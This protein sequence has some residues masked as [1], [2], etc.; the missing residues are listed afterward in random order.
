MFRFTEG[1]T[2][3]LPKVTNRWRIA[4][5]K[6]V[7][8]K[9]TISENEDTEESDTEESDMESDMDNKS[10]TL[11]DILAQLS[12]L[13]TRV[14]ATLRSLEDPSQSTSQTSPTSQNS[15]PSTTNT[16]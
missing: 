11:K 12:L 9:E 3:T 2:H 6:E 4:K 1:T 5:E 16:E 10:T 15:Q 13:Q 8:E 7:I 14:L